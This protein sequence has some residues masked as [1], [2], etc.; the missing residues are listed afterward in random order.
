[1]INKIDFENYLSNLIKE[2]YI[3]EKAMNYSLLARCKRIRPLLLLNILEDFGIDQQ[4]GF[5]CASSIEM[6]HTYSLIHDDLP[7]FDNDDYRR[8][9]LTCHKA[10]DEETAILAGDALLTFAFENISDSDY[11]PVIKVKL[12]K[13]ISQ[14]AGKDG[15][16]KGQSFDKDYENNNPSL[17]QLIEMDKL[18]TSRLLT[19]PLICGC[20]I[21]CK[22]QYISCLQ[23]VGD[24]LGVAFQ[25]QDDILDLTSNQQ[26][27]GK[28]ISDIKNQKSTYISLMSL[29]QAKEYVEKTFNEINE[30][31]A[32]Q[33][34]DFSNTKQLINSLINR[35]W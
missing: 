28:S 33:D 3:V 26:Q 13:Y 32:N 5:A 7:A 9:K 30:L 16:I 29:Q 22:E 12:I 17:Q 6:I 8:G 31:L 10:F 20:I 14:Y 27:L 25:I 15:M 11:D 18:K 1:M 2:D 34:I 23:L 21:A 35:K 4:I 24:K 19:L